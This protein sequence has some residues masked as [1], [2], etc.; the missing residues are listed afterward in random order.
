MHKEKKKKKMAE[1]ARQRMAEE[2]NEVQVRQTSTRNQE[3]DQYD[4]S[5][6]TIEPKS[7]PSAEEPE[8]EPKEQP[9]SPTSSEEESEAP[10]GLTPG[11]EAYEE[12]DLVSPVMEYAGD[13]V[14]E[15]EE[16]SADDAA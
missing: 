14:V 9:T 10:A 7:P 1:K 8:Q 5:D 6:E 13:P 2:M 3:A 12:W 15:S 4:S 16:L 11:E